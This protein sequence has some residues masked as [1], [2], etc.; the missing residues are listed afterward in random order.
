ME[1]CLKKS[2]KTTVL[3]VHVTFVMGPVTV[4]PVILWET[5]ITVQSFDFGVNLGSCYSLGDRHHN[6]II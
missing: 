2:P 1:L 6:T 3:V 5:D 4:L